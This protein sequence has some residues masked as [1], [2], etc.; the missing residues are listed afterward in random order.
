MFCF[1]MTLTSS[2]RLSTVDLAVMQTYLDRSL[3]IIDD[4][5]GG[6]DE[7]EARI[8]AL[9]MEVQSELGV[10]LEASRSPSR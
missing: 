7:R 5:R 8:R 4:R 10:M 1:R 6:L 2:S 3:L 9:L